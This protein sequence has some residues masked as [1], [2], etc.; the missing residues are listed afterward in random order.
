MGIFAPC[1]HLRFYLR[2]SANSTHDAKIQSRLKS[3]E[4]WSIS[5]YA[6]PRSTLQHAVGLMFDSVEPKLAETGKVNYVQRRWMRS[7]LIQIVRRWDLEGYGSSRVE[8]DGMCVH[9]RRRRRLV[10]ICSAR[11][12]HKHV[13]LLPFGPAQAPSLCMHA[14]LFILDL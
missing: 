10:F 2:T 8:T 6:P 3:C 12:T 1:R 14:A 11:S 4:S 5:S 7:P 9:V 13:P